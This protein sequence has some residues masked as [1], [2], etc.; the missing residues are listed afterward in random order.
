MT[1]LRIAYLINSVEGGGAASPVPDI[2]RVLRD[3]GA[4]VAVFALTRRDARGLPAMEDAGLDVRVRDGGETDHVAALRWIDRQVSEWRA[5]HLWTSLTQATL[6]GQI[7]GQRRGVPVVSWQ[8]NVPRNLANRTLLRLRQRHSALWIADSAAN[9]DVL[10][11]MIG[12]PQA[13]I[14]VWPIFRADPAAPCARTWQ[15]GEPLRIGSLGRLH[16]VKGYDVLANAIA[17]LRSSGVPAEV[18]IGGD[19]GLRDA[20]AG[21]PGIQLAGFVDQPRAFL[22]GLHLYVQPSRSEGLCVAA[23]EAMQAGLPVIGSAVGEMRHSIVPGETGWLVPPGDAPALAAAMGQAIAD[24]ARL[25]TMGI[26]ARAR[27]MER[28]APARFD[29]VGVEILARMS[30]MQRP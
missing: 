21:R 7:V 3:G 23:H 4:E 30:D 14:V 11:D 25:P 12:V 8:N 27:L 17:F 5:T 22:A 28:M 15:A 2:A 10:R 19:G 29:D 20:L 6:L 13:R 26:T 9:G 18:T 24:P 16:P 1:R